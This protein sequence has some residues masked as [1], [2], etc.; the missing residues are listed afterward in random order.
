MAVSMLLLL[1]V[2]GWTF[3][4]PHTRREASACR[5]GLSGPN[6]GRDSLHALRAALQGTGT[7]EYLGACSRDSARGG[8]E[9]FRMDLLL[10]VSCR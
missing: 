8:T 5:P 1:L 3:R 7:V 2:A 4:I 9:G 10:R 6:G